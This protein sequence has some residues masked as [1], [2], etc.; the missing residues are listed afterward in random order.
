MKNTD[1]NL[2]GIK[3]IDFNEQIKLTCESINAYGQFHDHWAIAWSMG[4]DSTTLLTLVIQL[5][6]TGQVMKPKSLTVLRADTRMELPP[7]WIASELIIE[8]LKAKGIEVR[9]VMADMDDRFMVYM[10]GLG[11]PPPSNTFRWC[12][13]QIKIE[14]MEMALQDL[15]NET[16]EKILMLT[17]VRQGESAIRDGKIHMSCSKGDAECGQGWYQT[18]L[19]TDLCS[20]LAPLLHWRVCSVWDWLKVFGPMEKNGAWP[21]AFLADAYGGDEAEEVAARTGCIGC[22]LASKDKALTEVIKI[23]AWRYLT[24]LMELKPLYREMKKKEYRHRKPGGEVRKDGQLSKNQQR[25][26][27]LTIEARIYFLDQILNIQNSVNSG[28][29]GMK[30][31]LID[32][33]EEARIRE[34]ISQKVYPQKWTG[35][36]PTGDIILDKQYSDGS[37]MGVLFRDWIGKSSIN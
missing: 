33:E 11:V 12:T 15:Y 21:T 26:G 9:T 30:L 22:P 16:G 18:G 25:L 19:S 8:K 32:Q 20:T 29:P 36:E 37:T 3:R 28:S 34:L 5:I 14:P 23:P 13:G 7:L 10:L 6:E 35:Q 27:P 2:F 1:L 17:G 24:P 31:Y 4:K